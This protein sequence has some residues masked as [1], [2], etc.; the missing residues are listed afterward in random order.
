MITYTQPVVA[1]AGTG[2]TIEVSLQLEGVAVTPLNVTLLDPCVAPNVVPVMV[3]AVPDSP[4]VG[5]KLVM[6]P[7]MFSVKVTLLLGTPLTVTTTGP[8]VV[9]TGTGTVIE[10]SDHAVGVA[11]MPLKVTVLLPCVA[12]K[13]Y[14]GMVM[15]CPICALEGERY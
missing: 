15:D 1:L 4:K 5:D 9:P 13:P 2:T 12:P 3:T 11:V 8:V 14:P 7:L 6:V 10:V